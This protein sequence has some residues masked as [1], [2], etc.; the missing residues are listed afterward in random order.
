MGKKC[1]LLQLISPGTPTLPADGMPIIRSPFLRRECSEPRLA[2]TRS[3][4]Y[5]MTVD[6]SLYLW[7]YSSVC[8]T[9]SIWAFVANLSHPLP[10][11]HKP[12]FVFHFEREFRIPL[13]CSYIPS[14]SPGRSPVPTRLERNISIVTD[15][16]TLCLAEGLPRSKSCLNMYPPLRSAQPKGTSLA[17][18]RIPRAGRGIH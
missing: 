15:A 13:F 10:P 11:R 18:R 9:H 5:S 14:L 16:T 8:L 12:R 1:R 3:R 6:A 4:N 7:R 2:Y 17:E